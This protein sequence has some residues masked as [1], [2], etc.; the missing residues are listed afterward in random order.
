MIQT[1]FNS[2]F[3]QIIE[4]V[5]PNVSNYQKSALDI[6]YLDRWLES[7]TKRPVQR[8]R[9]LL[10]IIDTR[11]S[12]ATPSDGDPL[13][14]D[15]DGTVTLQQAHTSLSWMIEHYEKD[16]RL[17]PGYEDLVSL[18]HNLREWRE[19]ETIQNGMMG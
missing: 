6:I 2:V 8:I 16:L 14:P 3:R 9:R 17:L 1:A 13:A 18:F 19:T 4:V 11:L 7:Q 5:F 15:P 10:N 12:A